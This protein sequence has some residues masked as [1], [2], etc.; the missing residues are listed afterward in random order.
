M[1]S[2]PIIFLLG[3]SGYYARS[4]TGQLLPVETFARVDNCKLPEGFA[5]EW[6]GISLEQQQAGSKTLIIL[7]LGLAFVFLVLAAQYESFKL[8]FVVILSVPRAVFGALGL[9]VMRGLVNDVFCQVG[10]AE[11]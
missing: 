7:L 2:P 8:P 6:T 11:P 4:E 3:P 9:Q 1:K 10:L 5:T